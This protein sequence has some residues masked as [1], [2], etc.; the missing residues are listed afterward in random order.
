ML[1][2]YQT[3]DLYMGFCKMEFPKE[4][5]YTSQTLYMPSAAGIG[6]AI[7]AQRSNQPSY[8]VRLP[9]SSH[10]A[11]VNFLHFLKVLEFS[12]THEIISREYV[13]ITTV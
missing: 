5:L 10:N 1:Y 3:S 13:E 8:R 9:D 6:P 2:L 12:S 11:N 7:P 4:N